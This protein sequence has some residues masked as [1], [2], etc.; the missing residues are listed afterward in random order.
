MM[1]DVENK[2]VNLKIHEILKGS[3]RL[4]YTKYKTPIM[5]AW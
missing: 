3:R 5:I 4:A 2:A 1:A